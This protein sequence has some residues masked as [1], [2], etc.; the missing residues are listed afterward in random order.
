VQF[1]NEPPALH[2]VSGKFRH[3]WSE[4]SDSALQAVHTV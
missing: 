3:V 4:V 1:S 2:P